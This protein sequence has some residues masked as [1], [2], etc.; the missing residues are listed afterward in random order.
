MMFNQPIEKLPF[1][2]SEARQLVSESD[3]D[4]QRD[5]FD[6]VIDIVDE[7]AQ[8][9]LFY[10]IELLHWNSSQLEF[11]FNFSDPLLIS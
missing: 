3:I 9:N 8:N 6:I 4:V 2:I 10:N 5:I 7:E 11:Q 1:T